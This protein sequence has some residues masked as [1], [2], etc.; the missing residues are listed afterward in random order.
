VHYDVLVISRIQKIAKL[1]H[2]KNT[3]RI[4]AWWCSCGLKNS[5]DCK[6]LSHKKTKTK[7]KKKKKKK[8]RLE[9]WWCSCGL[10]NLE[11]CKA[12][13]YKKKKRRRG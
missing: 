9:Q 2:E 3:K 5:E 11:Y 10:K 12:L 13:S 6:A 7:K 8:R 1:L 4:R